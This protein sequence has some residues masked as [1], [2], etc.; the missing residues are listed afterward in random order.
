MR[1]GLPPAIAPLCSCL[2]DDASYSPS[3]SALRQFTASKLVTYELSTRICRATALAR[4]PVAQGQCNRAALNAALL[5]T[6]ACLALMKCVDRLVSSLENSNNI[7]GLTRSKLVPGGEVITV[8]SI[9]SETTHLL[10]AVNH[11]RHWCHKLQ[12][13]WVP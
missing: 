1:Y 2:S 11:T 9:S 13:G 10:A 4:G 3:A 8:S 7:V 6:H 12:L 5:L